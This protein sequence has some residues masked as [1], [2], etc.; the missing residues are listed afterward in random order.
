M[1]VP[2]LSPV[3]RW[4]SF[5]VWPAVW[6]FETC[7]TTMIAWSERRWRP[8]IHPAAN[9]EAVEL[10]ELRAHAASARAS[11]LIGEREEGIILGAAVF[12]PPRA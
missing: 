3:M 5:S 10:L 1:G 7:V 12:E 4:F 2:A 6:V 8:R 11:R 9:F